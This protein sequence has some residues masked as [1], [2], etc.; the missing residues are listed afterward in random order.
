MQSS[1][2]K[3]VC[4]RPSRLSDGADED[5]LRELTDARNSR[6]KKAHGN[7]SAPKGEVAVGEWG[8]DPGLQP[9]KDYKVDRILAVDGTRALLK[10]KRPFD[11]DKYD[12]WIEL[13]D[14]SVKVGGR[15]PEIGGEEGRRRQSAS[16]NGH[17][18]TAAAFLLLLF[19]PF[20]LPSPSCA[21]SLT[22][23]PK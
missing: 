23:D 7:G 13:R 5:T 9:D 19:L 11:H 20:Y 15:D 2:P 21:P 22:E 18:L 16:D 10:F 4:R 8:E 3:R 12:A 6:K 1:R 17:F 14:M